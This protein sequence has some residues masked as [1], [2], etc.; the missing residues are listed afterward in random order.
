MVAKNSTSSAQSRE[1]IKLTA[2]KVFVKGIEYESL[3]KENKYY[4]C[5]CKDNEFWNSDQWWT[6]SY[7]PLLNESKLPY[8]YIFASPV[9]ITDLND[10]KYVYVYW[11]NS[12]SGD[13]TQILKQKMYSSDIKDYPESIWLM[14]DNFDT[15]IYVLFEYE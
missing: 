4:R 7:T 11:N 8:Q 14:N 2:P 13:G 5:V 12:T 9:E 10:D 15:S 6:T 3:G 1:T